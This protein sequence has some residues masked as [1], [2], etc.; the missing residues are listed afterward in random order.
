MDPHKAAPPGFI[1]GRV[2]PVMEWHS[3][4]QRGYWHHEG[5]HPA[6]AVSIRFGWLADLDEWYVGW[7]GIPPETWA[8]PRQQD[9]ELAVVELMACREGEWIDRLAN[10]GR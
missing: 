2:L 6:L 9:A 1:G 8:F 4:Q 7:S 5:T 3:R 10:P